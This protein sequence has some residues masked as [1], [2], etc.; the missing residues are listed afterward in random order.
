MAWRLPTAP[1]A[2]RGYYR[3]FTELGITLLVRPCKKSRHAPI[4][5][6]WIS[7]RVLPSLFVSVSISFSNFNKRRMK[8]GMENKLLIL[9]FNTK[10]FYEIT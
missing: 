7:Y 3:R 4:L 2:A 9:K 8:N 10:Y 1:D 5:V 6:I